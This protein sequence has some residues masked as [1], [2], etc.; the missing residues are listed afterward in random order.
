M[1]YLTP[2][3]LIMVKEQT[4]M[5]NNFLS[6]SYEPVSSSDAAFLVDKLYQQIMCNAFSKFSGKVLVRRL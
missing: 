6:K 5:L 3:D 4:E 1:K 2:D